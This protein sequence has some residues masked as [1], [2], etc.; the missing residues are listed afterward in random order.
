[1]KKFR[2]C[3]TQDYIGV[4]K[5][6]AAANRFSGLASPILNV[7]VDAILKLAGRINQTVE[8]EPNRGIGEPIKG[9]DQYDGCI[10]LLQKNQ[11]DVIF[12]IMDYPINIVNV[13]QGLIMG[14]SVLNIGSTYKMGG[15][16]AASM[17]SM[18]KSFDVPLYC[19][20]CLTLLTIWSLIW[21]RRAFRLRVL[22][23]FMSFHENGPN[24]KE[25][26]R[27]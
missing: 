21:V 10:G 7:I 3:H 20:V 14:S 8:V 26:K 1:M 2:I 18:F 11:S 23:P 24:A 13:S 9:T 25:M 15:G 4:L 5:F 19:T 12:M 6:E 17:L 22:R 27:K 16:N